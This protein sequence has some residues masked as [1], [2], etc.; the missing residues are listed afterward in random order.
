MKFLDFLLTLGALGSLLVA[1]YLFSTNPVAGSAPTNNGKVIPPQTKREPIPQPGPGQSTTPDD[2]SLP[3]VT[4]TYNW[5]YIVLHHSGTKNGSLKIFDNYHRNA[6]KQKDGIIYHFVIGNGTNSHDG[7]IEI[8]QRWLRQQPG[9]HC[10]NERISKSSI[11]ICLV[12]NFERDKPTASQV[13]TLINLT[14]RLQK[15]YR[16][17]LENV[18]LRSEVDKDRTLSPGRNFP[19]DTI[20]SALKSH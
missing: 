20:K 11:A 3:T 12:G 9:P 18:L 8:S 1:T 7:E 6:L 13:N 5:Q 15:E 19:W 16:I 10:F 2:G 4:T 14:K 17:P